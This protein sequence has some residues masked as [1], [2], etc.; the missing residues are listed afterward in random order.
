MKAVIPVAGAGTNLRPLTYTQPKPLIPV[1]GKP[2]LGYI[3]DQLLAVG[4]D[5]FVFVT[6][7]LAE[8]IEA[9]VNAAYPDLKKTFVLQRNRLGSA[10]AIWVAREFIQEESDIVIF[11]GDTIIDA[12][13]QK[14][15][16]SPTGCLAVKQVPDPRKVGVVEFDE[17]GM[18]KRLVEKPRI[19]K[20]NMAM[21][22]FYKIG[23]VPAL[24]AALDAG[25][26]DLPTDGSEFILT[27][28][29]T[30]ML[31]QGVPFGTQTVRNWFDCGQKD[32]LLATNR[33]LLEKAGY[34][35]SDLP[36]F[37]NSI[38]IHPV[39]I[40]KDCKISNS[41]VGPHVT[42]G[43]NVQLD[44]AIVRNSIVGN[45]ASIKEAVLQASIIGNDT[46]ITGM[47]Q[48]LNIGDNTEIDFS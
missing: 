7:Y 46:A 27:Q 33:M 18:V 10:H 14:M 47:K 17:A 29:L 42:L 36:T 24:L 39:T 35:H 43:S 19:P 3:I 30:H 5:E 32:V 20:S 4:V 16:D 12:D 31:D 45:Y 23:D 1:A 9:Y 38:I 25:M 40:G 26:Q 48:S 21:V 37:Y 6:G 41:I 28:A 15:L 13:I 34:N 11:F 8:K 44:S 2:I 22:G